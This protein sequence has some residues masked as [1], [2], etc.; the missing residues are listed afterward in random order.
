MNLYLCHLCKNNVRNDVEDN[1]RNDVRNNVE[2]NV[3]NDVRNNV[4]NNVMLWL[5]LLFL[6]FELLI[7]SFDSQYLI[8]EVFSLPLDFSDSLIVKLFL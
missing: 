7:L 8:V 5:F 6:L 2:D 4:K 3:T 1:V